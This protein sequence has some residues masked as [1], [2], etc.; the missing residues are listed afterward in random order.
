MIV[1][2][3]SGPSH[4]TQGSFVVIDPLCYWGSRVLSLARE[5]SKGTLWQETLSSLQYVC[6]LWWTAADSNHPSVV[7][8]V[9]LLR[10]SK[11]LANLLYGEG[12]FLPITHQIW[13]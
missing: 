6:M 7:L 2:I 13:L 11:A 1:F 10:S 9:A 8:E 12:V 5:Y 4:P 3:Q